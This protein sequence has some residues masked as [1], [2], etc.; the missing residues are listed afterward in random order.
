MRIIGA[1]ADDSNGMI[2]K[3]ADNTTTLA[4]TFTETGS[5]QTSINKEWLQMSP[6]EAK[7][8]AKWITST[9]RIVP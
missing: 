4:F 2:I 5:L 9:Q 6:N 1:R 8:L 3:S 7:E